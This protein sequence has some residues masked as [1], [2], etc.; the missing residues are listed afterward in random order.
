MKDV[1]ELDSSLRWIHWRLKQVQVGKGAGPCAAELCFRKRFRRRSR[2]Q[3]LPLASLDPWFSLELAPREIPRVK[4]PCIE[5]LL[6]PDTSSS[7]GAKVSSKLSNPIKSHL[8]SKDISLSFIHQDSTM[9]LNMSTMKALISKQ[10]RDGGWVKKL[11]LYPL[12]AE[13]S[14]SLPC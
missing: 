13:C 2:D 3:I 5:S 12:G 8:N 7:N 10:P 14:R 11:L 9:I 1:I 4:A 6:V